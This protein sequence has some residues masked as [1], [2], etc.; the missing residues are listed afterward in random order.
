M[1]CQWPKSDCSR[2][3]RRRFQAPDGPTY[4]LCEEHYAEAKKRLRRKIRKERK[5]KKVLRQVKTAAQVAAVGA[6]VATAAGKRE[7]VVKNKDMNALWIGCITVSLSAVA[8]ASPNKVIQGYPRIID[9]DSL[10]I[11][12]TSIRLE[13]ID[14][15]EMRQ[16]CNKRSG[17]PY[18]CGVESRTQLVNKIDTSSVS[19]SINRK[20]RYGR[21]LGYC[22]L[23][24][25]G[26]DPADSLNAWM[27]RS[28]HA[29]AYRR[30][31]TVFVPQEENARSQQVGI[32]SGEFLEPWVWRQRYGTGGNGQSSGSSNEPGCDIKGN[33]SSNG[34][35]IYHLPGGR[36]YDQVKI[37]ESKG[38]RWF[39]SEED[40]VSLGWRASRE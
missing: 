13:A 19:C 38:E 8:A 34:E 35:K 11:N 3:R 5:K 39:C 10:E 24:R 25:Q 36:Y 7:A 28:G 14:A 21:S 26:Q 9:G 30:F 40:A 12:K 23:G 1:S 6:Q 33:I 22:W 15:P 17:T 31:S 32:W 20:D 29:L 37:T 16:T 27:V 4:Y 18:A 2:R